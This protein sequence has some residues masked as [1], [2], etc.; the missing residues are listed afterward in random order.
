M[1]K[2]GRKKRARRKHK[3]NHGHRPGQR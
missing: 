1:A 3:A 2:R